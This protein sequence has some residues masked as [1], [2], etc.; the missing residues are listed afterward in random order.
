VSER[1]ARI[2]YTESHWVAMTRCYGVMRHIAKLIK[3]YA[4]K[5][6][7]FSARRRLDVFAELYAPGQFTRN[8]W[9]V[10]PRSGLNHAEERQFLSLPG[11]ELRT[12]CRPAR[13]QSLSQNQSDQ[14]DRAH[15]S[16]QRMWATGFIA[17]SVE[18]WWRRGRG[19]PSRR[20]F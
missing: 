9:V 17:R 4:V 15:A 12:L 2:R 13:S 16:Q 10:G 20:L 14:P 11:L 18:K 8:H 6:W 1:V 19:R 7:G 3:H 5:G